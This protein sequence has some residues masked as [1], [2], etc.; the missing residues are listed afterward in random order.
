M[1][2]AHLLS[3]EPRM[4]TSEPIAAAAA[5][6]QDRVDALEQTVESLRSELAE[7]RT[8]FEEFKREFR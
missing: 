1:R 7:L 6:R 3:G 8:Q 4:D 2:Y 5:P